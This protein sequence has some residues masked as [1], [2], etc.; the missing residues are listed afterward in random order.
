VRWEQQEEK[1]PMTASYRHSSAPGNVPLANF[2]D[3]AVAEPLLVHST[4]N[5]DDVLWLGNRPDRK[6]RLRPK[7]VVDLFPGEVLRPRERVVLSRL[8]EGE[9]LFV[10]SVG[11]PPPELRANTDAVCHALLQRLTAA[12]ATNEGYPLLENIEWRARP[13]QP[14]ERRLPPSPLAKLLARRLGYEL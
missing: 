4:D 2:D 5:W 1:T 11:V 8:C 3:E 12:G 9:I 10:T 7:T 6:Y 13:P 14:G